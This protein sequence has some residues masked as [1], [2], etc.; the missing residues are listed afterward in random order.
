MLKATATRIPGL[1]VVFTS[2]ETDTVPH[3]LLIIYCLCVTSDHIKI[4]I[5]PHE[6]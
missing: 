5:Q 3:I 6:L 2:D 1:D 4:A